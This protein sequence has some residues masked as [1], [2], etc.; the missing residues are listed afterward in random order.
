MIRL[1]EALNYRCLKRVR[2]PLDSF[3]V[4]VGPNS[5]GKSSFLD[6]LSFLG[7]L[8]SDGLEA[9]IGKRG[10]S[11]YDL[12]WQR[13]GN[14]F[15]LA[16]E[17]VV[18]EDRR[19]PI[20]IALEGKEYAVRYELAIGLNEHNEARILDEQILLSQ[21]YPGP[22]AQPQYRGANTLFFESDRRS[23]P[24]RSL[25]WPGPQSNEY[26]VEVEQSPSGA[27]RVGGTGT[28]IYRP[29]NRPIFQGL[30]QKGYPTAIWLDGILQRQIV[31]VDLSS[32]DLRN[33]SRPG[34]PKQFAKTGSN[35][36]WLI[37]AFQDEYPDRYADWILHVRQALPDVEGIR[38]AENPDT[39]SRFLMV[40]YP[41][42]FE[43]PSW[44]LSDGTLRLLALTLAAYLPSPGA[45]HLIEEPE[46]SIHPLNIEIVTQSL[47]SVYDGQVLVSTHSPTV[48][49]VTKPEH[50]LV[51]S[52][53]E[54][55]GTSIVRGSEHP[56]LRQWKGQ[57]NLSVLYASGVLG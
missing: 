50:V 1:V 23:K 13:S 7:D 42:G 12:F 52:R 11:I 10:S 34:Q 33:A 38:V 43:L 44:L 8:A 41:S 14:R 6:V 22:D 25:V 15:E 55:N 29:G 16:V 46:T 56:E 31:P 36:P 19:P 18:P 28:A 5:S 20:G 3:Q 45:V 26:A 37:G 9:A 48:L 32:S 17:A 2:Q 47:S 40:R 27:A 35:L 51:F 39:R 4:L 24:W 21:D 57:P 30:Y 54:E 53:D 49:S